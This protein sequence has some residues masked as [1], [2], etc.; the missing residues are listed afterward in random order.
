M[1][2]KTESTIRAQVATWR[3]SECPS[4]R[5]CGEVMFAILED[6]PVPEQPAGGGVE[7]V[8]E[9]VAA[10]DGIDGKV[11]D[12]HRGAVPF[13]R[14]SPIGTKLYP[15]LPP[16][17]RVDDAAVERALDAFDNVY[18]G[19]RREAAMRAALEAGGPADDAAVREL[20]AADREYD[21]ASRYDRTL[22]T[23]EEI[24]RHA[25]ADLRRRRA[26]SALQAARPSEPQE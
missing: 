12:W 6:L 19:G 20:I 21:A 11:L 17:A 18:D 9:I 24:Q 22:A 10:E 5:Y 7:A 23:P 15:H 4:T 26:L 14:D 25:E 3:E 16:P 1:L 2:L 8:A 13:I